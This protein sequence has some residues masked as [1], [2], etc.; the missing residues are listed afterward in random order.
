MTGE[1]PQALITLG[2]RDE[3]IRLLYF[4]LSCASPC[5]V[6]SSLFLY[7]FIHVAKIQVA[8]YHRIS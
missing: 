4:S 8:V 6:N 2:I 7:G 1:R 5:Q 3:S